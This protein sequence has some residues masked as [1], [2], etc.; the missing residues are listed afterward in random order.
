[1]GAK[2]KQ[3]QTI[4]YVGSTG[5]S[6]GPHLD[7]RI[8]EKERFFDFLK[9]KNRSSAVKDVSKEPRQ[10]F[11]DLKVLYLKELENAKQGK[12]FNAQEQAHEA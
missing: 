12:P 6:T 9:F 5:L 1:M 11:E 10:E 7:F 2:V 4:G 8:K 3:G